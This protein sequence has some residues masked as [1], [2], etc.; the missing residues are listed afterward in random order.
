M[1]AAMPR[2]GRIGSPTAGRDHWTLAFAIVMLLLFSLFLSLYSLSKRES[3]KLRDEIE[4]V[5]NDK[6]KP[7]AKDVTVETASAPA[8]AADVG[9]PNADLQTA[10]LAEAKAFLSTDAK[11]RSA[12]DRSIV[13][14]L[15][16]AGGDFLVRVAAPD[17]FVPGSSKVTQSVRPF[18]DRLGA[19]IVKSGRRLRIEGH[20]DFDDSE[21]IARK[22]SAYTNTWELSGARAAALAQ[23]WMRKF[24]LDPTKIEAAGYGKYRPLEAKTGRP[25]QANRRIEIVI[26]RMEKE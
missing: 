7:A 11:G 4:R 14:V 19:L 6:P 16:L 23:Y 12:K 9:A 8:G 2:S 20:A 3:A 22:A 17:L 13:E 15:D 1:S 10:I 21:A 5:R 26:L 25:S 18:V 24:D